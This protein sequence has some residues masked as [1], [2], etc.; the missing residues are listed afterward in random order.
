MKLPPMG[1]NARSYMK[2]ITLEEKR[3]KKYLGYVINKIGI[4]NKTD[5]LIL[6]LHQSQYKKP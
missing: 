5:I 6:V 1:I 3:L 4:L 2:N